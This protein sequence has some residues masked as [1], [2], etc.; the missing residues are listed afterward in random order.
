[1]ARRKSGGK[2]LLKYL[3]TLVKYNVHNFS[4]VGGELYFGFGGETPFLKGGVFSKGGV[5]SIYKIKEDKEV[6][7]I[8]LNPII[9]WEVP[10]M[11]DLFTYKKIR[12]NSNFL[13]F[14]DVSLLI[15]HR[16]YAIRFWK[17]FGEGPL[18]L[19]DLNHSAPFIFI[20]ERSVSD[21]SGESFPEL[22]QVERKKVG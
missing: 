7:C 22:F 9:N 17:A 21:W 5:L 6:V 10:K 19:G 18:C 20:A 12:V 8:T 16:K 13:H 14:E 3:E 2:E 11:W 1:M 15:N 4:F